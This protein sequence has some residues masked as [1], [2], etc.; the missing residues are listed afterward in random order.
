MLGA[1]LSILSAASFALNITAARRGVVTGSPSQGTALTIPIGVACF[2]PVAIATGEIARLPSFPPASIAWMAAVGLLHFL[3][4]RYSNYRA[5]QAA[6]V[7]ITGPVVQLQVV[8]TLVLAVAVLREPCSVLQI[9]GGMVMLAGALVT[10][11]QRPGAPVAL[12]P[13]DIAATA[14]NPD[15]ADDTSAAAGVFVPRYLAG[16]LFASVAALA[17]GTTPIMTRFA[18]EH[19]G[20]TSGILAG[21][22]AYGAAT[23]VVAVAL[24]WPP[25]WREV[26]AL[27]RENLRWFVYSGV[28]VA[29][30]QGFFYSA[31]AVAPIMLVAPLLQLSLVFRL[32]FS[33]W[34][35]PRH[36]VFGAL[37]IAG[38]ATS[39]V[40]ALAIAVDT[41][42]IVNVVAV[43]EELARVLRWRI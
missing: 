38:A 10:Q 20:P 11:W 27:K 40:G 8:V 17:Y 16:Y 43:P 18:L 6:G 30:A 42:V 28:L 41:D 37:V 23:A 33:K 1:I 2:L 13:A 14:R 3:I 26:T 29:L 24:A 15:T 32:L 7:N 39:I 34:L 21:L 5:N 22:I 9:I 35:N 12:V 4:G 31:L 19:T 36:E 25:L